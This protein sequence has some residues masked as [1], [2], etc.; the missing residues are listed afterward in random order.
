MKQKKATT[1]KPFL[2]LI[3]SA[4]IPKLA[5]SVGLIAGMITTLAGLVVPVLTKN[6]VDD[7]SASSLSV[8]LVVA[9][10][11]AFIIQAILGGISLYFLAA[12]GQKV[13]DKL[14]DKIWVRLIRLPVKYFDKT[15]SGETVSRVVNDTNIVKD[16]ISEHFPQFIS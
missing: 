15:A 7:F 1:I 9:I 8:P 16:L 2:S 10:I 12:V 6:L 3:L 4:N 5:L 11:I 13:V 14:R